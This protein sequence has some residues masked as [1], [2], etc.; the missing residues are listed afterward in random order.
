LQPRLLPWQLPGGEDEGL[1]LEVAELEGEG[2]REGEALGEGE[3]EGEGDTEL[4][5]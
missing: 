1:K 2:L 4:A 3:G 5:H